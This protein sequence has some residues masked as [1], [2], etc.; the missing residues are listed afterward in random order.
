MREQST[1][2]V[3]AQSIRYR[4]TTF[5]I[6]D[7]PLLWQQNMLNQVYEVHKSDVSSDDDMDKHFLWYQSLQSPLQKIIFY[8]LVSCNCFEVHIKN[9]F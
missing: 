1:L 6:V 4:K 9:I 2:H 8:Y 7:K 5:K 3:I